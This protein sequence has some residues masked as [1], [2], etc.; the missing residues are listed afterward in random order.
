M[1]KHSILFILGLA[2]IRLF[3]TCLLGVL[4][5]RGCGQLIIIGLD[6]GSNVHFGN[7]FEY[8]TGPDVICNKSGSIEIPRIIGGYEYNKRYIVVN[9]VNKDRD[10]ENY[11]GHS[12]M[13]Y[14][15]ID[16]EDAI[17]YGPMD[18]RRFHN[19][20]DSLNVGLSLGKNR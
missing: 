11:I 10:S 4:T 12:T 5:L 13:S 19:L 1:Q 18:Y 14:W 7:D 15:I 17:S 9:Q 8:R 2:V 20:C 16:K 3:I 6:Y